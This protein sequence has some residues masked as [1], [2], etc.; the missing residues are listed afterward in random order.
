MRVNG[1]WGR[2]GWGGGEAWVC[3]CVTAAGIKEGECLC[4]CVSRSSYY[5]KVNVYVLMCREKVRQTV[6]SQTYVVT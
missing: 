2:K 5:S 1:R 6:I 4:V 3:V